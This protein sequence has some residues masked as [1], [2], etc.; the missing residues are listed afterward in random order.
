VSLS[1][2]LLSLGVK[3]YRDGLDRDPTTVALEIATGLKDLEGVWEL[4]SS[5]LGQNPHENDSEYLLARL[6]W[7][8]AADAATRDINLTRSLETDV[9][10]GNLI[11]VD[12]WLLPAT[13]ARLYALAYLFHLTN[14][15]KP[16]PVK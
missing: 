13:E 6:T 10:K 1:A 7:V 12:G 15:P 11:Q 2:G 8:E 14:K 9:E 3:L 4:G 16:E 5:Y